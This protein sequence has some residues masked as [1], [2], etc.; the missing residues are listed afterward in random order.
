MPF[1]PR[2]PHFPS[3]FTYDVLGSG[4]QE[5]GLNPGPEWSAGVVAH[6]V[7]V[8]GVGHGNLGKCSQW[9]CWKFGLLE[10]AKKNTKN[11]SLSIILFTVSSVAICQKEGMGYGRQV[12]KAGS[13]YSFWVKPTR[14]PQAPLSKIRT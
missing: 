4:W 9:V 12:G 6:L 5:C 1:I 13:R 3:L 10:A 14:S 11:K 2:S 7:W 8:L